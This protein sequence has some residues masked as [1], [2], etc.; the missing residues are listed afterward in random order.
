MINEKHA[1]STGALVI[2]PPKNI[3]LIYFYTKYLIVHNIILFPAP[4]GLILPSLTSDTSTSVIIVWGPPTEPNGDIIS[5]T[6]QRQQIVADVPGDIFTVVTLLPPM[7]FN[8]R[9]TSDLVMPYTTYEYRIIVANAAGQ[10]IGDWV[11]V[12]TDSSSKLGREY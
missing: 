11:R 9:D 4:E 7:E 10:S 3:I 5:Y 1:V 8:Y 6:I 2:K 12:V